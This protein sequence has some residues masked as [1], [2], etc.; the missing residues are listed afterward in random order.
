MK[1]NP[2]L[3]IPAMFPWSANTAADQIDVPL[4]LDLE[5]RRL[6]EDQKVNLG[7]AYRGKVLLIVNTASK[8]GF[9]GQYAGLEK[10]YDQYRE[11]GLVVLGFPSNDF[12]G[13][14]P[15]TEKQIQDFCRLT[16]GVKFP[17]FEKS[18]VKKSSASALYERLGQ[19]AGYPRWNFHKYLV[20]SRGRLVGSY[21]SS[22]E[23]DSGPLFEHVKYLMSTMNP[24]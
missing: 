17:M 6:D 21:A 19:A 20:D 14:E 18:H 22:M 5:V 24:G 12:A 2:L 15:G 23:P 10:L 1:L 9:T 11:N 3:I 16:Y 8:C 7:E 4:D 13:Q